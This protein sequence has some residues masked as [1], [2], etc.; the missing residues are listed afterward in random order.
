MPAYGADQLSDDQVRQIS[1]W[2]S[3]LEVAE[4]GHAH[5]DEAHAATASVAAHVRLMALVLQEPPNVL[6]VE[7]HLSH[8]LAVNQDSAVADRLEQVRPMLSTSPTS[9]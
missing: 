6:G 2:T 4:R 9:M 5:A 8:A 1:T 7:H 3:Q